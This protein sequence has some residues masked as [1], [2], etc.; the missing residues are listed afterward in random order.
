MMYEAKCPICGKVNVLE[1][2]ETKLMIY[3]SGLGKIQ[4][5]FPEL[6]CEQRELIQSGICNTCWNELFPDD[7][8]D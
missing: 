2:D 4:D 3:K 7:E 5:I 6:T 1:I 8:E